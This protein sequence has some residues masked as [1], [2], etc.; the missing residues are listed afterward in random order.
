MGVYN[1]LQPLTQY[2]DLPEFQQPSWFRKRN[3]ES[4][5]FGNIFNAAVPALTTVAGTLIGGPAGTAIGSAAGQ[6]IVGGVNRTLSANAKKQGADDAQAT[7][8]N[9]LP[10]DM[11][12][13]GFTSGLASMVGFT[14]GKAGAAGSF[15][16]TGM[17]PEAVPGMIGSAIGAFG[18]RP[19]P[20]VPR[21]SAYRTFGYADG[22]K[23][24]QKKTDPKQQ[25]VNEGAGW[26]KNWIRGRAAAEKGGLEKAD[27][28]TANW[29]VTPTLIDKAPAESPDAY[30]WYNTGTNRAYVTRNAP[31]PASSSAHE[32]TH[33]WQAAN[34]AMSGAKPYDMWGHS[35]DVISN[36]PQKADQAGA[37]PGTEQWDYE[38]Y[39]REPIEVHARLMEF[40]KKAGF[41]PGQTLTKD[42]VN[43]ALDL[44]KNEL[45]TN[46]LENIYDRDTL[47]DLLNK[48]VS[49][50]MAKNDTGEFR[51]AEGGALAGPP[52]RRMTLASLRGNT[53]YA[54]PAATAAPTLT[55]EQAVAQGSDFTQNWYQTKVTN[56]MSGLTPADQGIVNG[57]ADANYT[58]TGNFVTGKNNGSFLDSKTIPSLGTSYVNGAAV[59]R[60]YGAAG[61]NDG[62]SSVAAHETNHDAQAEMGGNRLGIFRAINPPHPAWK[63]SED[64]INQELTR[65][66]LPAVGNSEK[67]AY[68][69]QPIEVHSGV[70]Q[71]RQENGFKP[72]QVITEQD[73]NR[74]ENTPAYRRMGQVLDRRGILNV[75]NKTVSNDGGPVNPLEDTGEF[76]AADGGS[77]QPIRPRSINTNTARDRRRQQ[78]LYDGLGERVDREL[79]INA[80]EQQKAEVRR[81]LAGYE[82]GRDNS[83]PAVRTEENRP[84]AIAANLDGADY[85]RRYVAGRGYPGMVGQIRTPELLTPADYKANTGIDPSTS[86][87]VYMPGRDRSYT[88]DAYGNN[89]TRT[90]G[91]EE[92]THDAQ[93]ALRNTPEMQQS[94]ATIGSRIKPGEDPYLSDPAEVQARLMRMR[95]GINQDPNQK[96]NRGKWRMANLAN[97]L[98][99]GLANR[100]QAQAFRDAKSVMGRK[101]VFESL[102]DTFF[103]GGIAGKKGSRLY[104]P[105]DK[106]S[107]DILMIDKTTGKHVGQMR[108]RERIYDQEA[109]DKIDTSVSTL[110]QKPTKKGFELLG[111]FLVDETLTH[112]DF[113]PGYA[114]GGKPIDPKEKEK[115]VRE[116]QQKMKDAGVYTGPID[117]TLRAD[118]T[119]AIEKWNALP[120]TKKDTRIQIAED[121]AG[122][123]IDANFRGKDET[124]YDT[125]SNA[126][127]S[128]GGMNASFV[129]EKEKKK[130]T[131]AQNNFQPEIL[132]DN[133]PLAPEAPRKTASTVYGTDWEPD[134]S[135]VQKPG[136][137]KPA[138]YNWLS[139]GNVADAARAFVGFQQA[140]RPLPENPINADY[141][142]LVGEAK[143]TRNDGLGPASRKLYKDQIDDTRSLQIDA[144][145][146]SAGGGGSAGAVLGALG[147]INDATSTAALKL[148]AADEQAKMINQS[149]YQGLLGGQVDMEQ[150]RFGMAYNAALQNRQ[151]GANLAQAGLQGIQGRYDIWNLYDR[152]GSPGQ[153][154][155]Q[156]QAEN[157]NASTQAA[158]RSYENT[159]NI[160]TRKSA[161]QWPSHLQ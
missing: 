46:D 116:L 115:A 64:V 18:R 149:R 51:A 48:T 14:P 56:S 101:A 155:A 118:M 3:G 153:V 84:G 1:N 32:A 39:R 144:V 25:Q 123:L 148:A 38:R 78:R 61:F 92:S 82:A 69:R 36:A 142:A 16:L 96:F 54:A 11:Q 99:F 88:V 98:T 30:G 146:K 110:A 57:I 127:I 104:D 161:Y 60:N 79:D 114:G 74:I 73:L 159:G 95:G 138:G 24:V 71:L 131:V 106:T 160:L 7:I 107:E 89:E 112:K 63:A 42:V 102:D 2:A 9:S 117:G 85:T 45:F 15:N 145:R 94:L 113:T 68:V 128:D 21:G 132:T 109:S 4:T 70:M 119:P 44:H 43:K 90:A 31:N 72:G 81:L 126:T 62:L 53:A 75:L 151:M 135:T 47:L 108:Y 111:R 66:N 86:S 5:T 150:Q 6:A 122:N 20:S 80:E 8:D 129:Y 103:A 10:Q 23:P 27:A 154:F 83:T 58:P 93:D 49:N 133:V 13:A 141:L 124:T 52:R 40:R 134:R 137:P 29:I 157:I 97:T 22:G 67:D 130:P 105:Q 91:I 87:G 28:A 152:P 41:K 120:T 125:T 77:I 35:F 100:G 37:P 76:R 143:G 121:E 140:S 136:P 19:G 33:S 12:M 65:S 26:L 55:P 147:T 59:R 50:D 156:M 158:K 139:M 34:G 17:E